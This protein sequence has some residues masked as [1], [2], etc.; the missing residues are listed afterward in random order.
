MMK[1]ILLALMVTLLTSAPALAG[2]IAE[3]HQKAKDGG[4]EKEYEQQMKKLEG[5]R[6]KRS[7][8]SII[9]SRRKK[10]RRRTKKKITAK[11]TRRNSWGR[12]KRSAPGKAIKPAMLL[13]EIFCR[14]MH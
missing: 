1:K 2:S 4:Y 9:G 12:T 7:M 8:R 10:T 6:T 3:E 13:A 14:S 11:R 5:W